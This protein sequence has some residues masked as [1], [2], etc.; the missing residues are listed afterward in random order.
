MNSFGKNIRKYR[1]LKGLS[2]QELGALLGFSTRT[3]SDWECNNTEPNVETIRK[4]VKVLDI[5][6][7]ELFDY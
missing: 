5:A 1:K 4:L 6:Y 3:V 7:E 2:Q